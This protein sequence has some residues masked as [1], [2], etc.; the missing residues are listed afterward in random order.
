FS[1]NSEGEATITATYR[2]ASAKALITVNEP[3]VVEF[4][5]EPSEFTLELG[6]ELGLQAFGQLSNGQTTELTTLV[7]WSSGTPRVLGIDVAGRVT[8]LS[9][10]KA[11]L[12]AT[13]DTFEAVSDGNVPD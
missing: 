5:I 2:G 1:A 7:K 3:L 13:Y 12:T 10:G 4:W 9:P 6:K 8:A 11:Q